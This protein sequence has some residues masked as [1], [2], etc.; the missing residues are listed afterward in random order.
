VESWNAPSLIQELTGSR[1]ANVQA[2]YNVILGLDCLHHGR[3][4]DEGE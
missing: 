1:A 4:Q 2:R 3:K